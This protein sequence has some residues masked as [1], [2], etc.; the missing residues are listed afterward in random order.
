MKK[1]ALEMSESE[2]DSVQVKLELSKS[3]FHSDEGITG[4]FTIVPNDEPVQALRIFMLLTGTEESPSGVDKKT[5]IRRI[6][7][8]GQEIDVPSEKIEEPLLLPFVVRTPTNLPSSYSGL[9]GNIRYRLTGGGVF[10]VGR[11]T[12]RARVRLAGFPNIQRPLK[13]SESVAIS[14]FCCC[15]NAG[16]VQ[17]EISSNSALIVPG[18]P[19]EFKVKVKNSC[20][21]IF[22]NFRFLLFQ[23]VSCSSD[24]EASGPRE[25]SDLLLVAE[26]PGNS[27]YE[28]S[29]RVEISKSILPSVL[30]SKLIKVETIAKICG[31]ISGERKAPSLKTSLMVLPTSEHGN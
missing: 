5:K 6:C 2:A 11:K 27:V 29:V 21:E 24:K 17:L 26:I 16:T 30:D 19:V 13:A 3:L 4:T 23:N 1:F 28:K 25:I 22:T 15:G 18:E 14:A 20:A 12:V 9:A 31:E 7:E 8:I 10:D